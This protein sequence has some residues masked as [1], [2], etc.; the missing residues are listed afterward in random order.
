MKKQQ[1]KQFQ[2]LMQIHD[3][4][5]GDIYEDK[6]VA[7]TFDDIKHAE[8]CFRYLQSLA[9]EESVRSRVEKHIKNIA[10]TSVKGHEN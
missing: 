1:T 3:P 8:R 7:F 4:E 6:Q 2:I 5:I 10:S 9:R